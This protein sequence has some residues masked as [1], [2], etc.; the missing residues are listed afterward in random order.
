MKRRLR[1]FG[2][3]SPRIVAGRLLK[4]PISLKLYE[5]L[6]QIGFRETPWQYIYDSQLAGLVLPYDGNNEV[7]IRF[8]RD[9]IFAELEIG[10]AF[11]SHFFGP[12]FN[13]IEIVLHKTAKHITKEERKYL[14]SM[15][16]SKSIREDE[17]SLVKWM[18]AP[19]MDP[20]GNIAQDCSSKVSS[21]VKRSCAALQWKGI[22]PISLLIPACTVSIG[23]SLSYLGLILFVLASIA[24]VAMPAA[25]RPGWR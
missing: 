20:Y 19:C 14:T 8:Y 1:S 23:S 18:P 25:G 6:K 13:A 17:R 15:L 24:F 22:I 21:L 16:Y 9:R 12:Q 10:R 2:I 11:V 4:D 5:K 3:L 7:H